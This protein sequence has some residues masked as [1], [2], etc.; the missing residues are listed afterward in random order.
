MQTPSP[1]APAP[2]LP[3]APAQP[4]MHRLASDLADVTALD[5][6][7]HTVLSVVG[8]VVRPGPVRDALSG[9]FLGHALHPLLTDLPIGAWTSALAL[10]LVGGPDSAPAARRLIG[11]GIAAA[12][13]TALTGVVEWSD[14]ARTRSAT[15][16]VGLVHGLANATA[17]ALFTASYARRRNGGGRL[18]ALA[19]A[20]ALAVGGHLGG[21][22]S[23]VHGE[24]VARTTF[25][26]GPREWTPTIPAAE[27]GDGQMTCVEA[28]GEAILLAREDGVVYAL[29]DHC[30]HR[31]GRL[32]EGELSDG[33]VTCPLH[34]S[35]FALADGAVRRGPAGSPQPA[36]ETRVRDG[37]IEVRQ[38]TDPTP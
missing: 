29:A 36:Y 23:Y 4:R 17:L 15:R 3:T 8:R 13:P 37:R 28:H 9:T 31:G 38:T 7:A 11:M 21:H 19:G 14:S 16:R 34:G 24:G 22:L 6:P 2:H 18:L 10:D 12:L 26:D 32:H 5:P 35:R 1:V 27:L 20:G 25:E 30:N 33:C